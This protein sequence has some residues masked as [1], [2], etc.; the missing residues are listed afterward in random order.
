MKNILLMFMTL[1]AMGVANLAWSVDKLVNTANLARA[2]EIVQG[3]C[4][5]CH[6]LQGESSSPIYPRLAGQHAEY[7]RK[8]L[9]NYKSGARKSDTMQAQV[10]ELTS[11][12][13]L[14]LGA[15]FQAK[16][17]PPSD[18]TDQDLAG[19]G[20]YLY[21]KG[22]SYSGVPACASCHG[23]TGLGTAQ[24]PRLAGQRANYTETQLKNFNKRLRT[25][26]NEVMH[27]I[28]SKLTELEMHA[29]AEYIS[30]LRP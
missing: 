2:E 26:D 1:V 23:A 12:D 11:E 15:F 6:G 21:Q 8:Q 24:L 3:Q 7:I 22:K 30:S 20:R 19:M 4:F 10:T 27:S 29:V 9:E 18:P 28:A 14:A 16:T 5:V 17:S 13:I 25:N